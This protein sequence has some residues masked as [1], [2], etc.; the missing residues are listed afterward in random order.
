MIFAPRIAPRRVVL[1]P[2]S[3][4]GEI[5]LCEYNGGEDEA[6]KGARVEFFLWAPDVR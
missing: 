5:E 2:H 3:I 4:E 6:S 1:P